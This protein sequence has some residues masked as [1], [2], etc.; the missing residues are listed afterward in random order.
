VGK[1]EKRIENKVKVEMG[2]AIEIEVGIN[3][4]LFSTIY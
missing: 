4:K 2:L 3:L 1:R